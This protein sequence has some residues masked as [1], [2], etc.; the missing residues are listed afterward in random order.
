[1]EISIVWMWCTIYDDMPSTRNFKFR[2][3]FGEYLNGKSWYSF[4]KRSIT[5]WLAP[6]ALSTSRNL[7]LQGTRQPESIYQT[8]CCE[9]QVCNERQKE[10]TVW[11]RNILF[12]CCLIERK[13]INDNLRGDIRT[14]F[15]SNQLNLIIQIQPV[16]AEWFPCS[17]NKFNKTLNYWDRE[18]LICPRWS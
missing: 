7:N 17:G 4:L 11:S 14:P 16:F 13:T 12:S 15:T 1:M 10:S 2:S 3:S 18:A 5:W 6:A 9:E 8:S